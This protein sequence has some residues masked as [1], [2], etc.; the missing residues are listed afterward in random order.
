M[1][2]FINGDIALVYA[3]LVTDCKARRAVKT[4]SLSTIPCG[5]EFFLAIHIGTKLRGITDRESSEF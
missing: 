2:T 1:H 5:L 3:L 4:G